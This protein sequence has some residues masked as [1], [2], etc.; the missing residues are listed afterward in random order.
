MGSKLE[1][2]ILRRHQTLD[3]L[4]VEHLSWW[5][6]GTILTNS[7]QSWADHM[8]ARSGTWTWWSLS[9]NAQMTLS[10]ISQLSHWW[11]MV[12]ITQSLL[13]PM[14]HLQ[15]TLLTTRAVYLTY[16]TREAGICTSLVCPSLKTITQFSINNR[17]R[18]DS[19]DR[20][21]VTKI[22]LFYIPP[23]QVIQ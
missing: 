23:F 21:I 7:I 17:K 3:L 5:C 9:V 22:L 19:L 1:T 12:L 14:C 20:S 2:L 6:L 4:I 11:L 13:Q 18:L 16:H 10:K 15:A 8:H